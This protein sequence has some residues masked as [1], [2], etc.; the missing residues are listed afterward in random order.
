VS[1]YFTLYVNSVDDSFA[2]RILKFADDN[3]VT[4]LLILLKPFTA[5]EQ[6]YVIL[7]MVHRTIND[8]VQCSEVQSYA[9]KLQL[10]MLNSNFFSKSKLESKTPKLKLIS[11]CIL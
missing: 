4:I 9:C 8:T 7:C 3:K 6:I 5:Y 10:G 2:N 1:C 11:C